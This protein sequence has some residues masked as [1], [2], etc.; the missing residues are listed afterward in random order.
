MIKTSLPESITTIDQAKAFLQSLHDNGE[1]YHPED[2]ANSIEWMNSDETNPTAEECEQL[3]KLMADIYA[4]G[5]FDPC[6]YL[7]L[8]D[9]ISAIDAAN[10]ENTILQA[11]AKQFPEV[12]YYAIR[13]SNN[14]HGNFELSISAP[15]DNGIDDYLIEFYYYDKT[16][17]AEAD[18]EQLE[19]LGFELSEI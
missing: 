2:D 5:G 19:N 6:E 14:P 4:I 9:R 3:N 16:E 1:A 12:L 8:L 17:E 15:S 13:R 10:F 7:L 11:D 18:V